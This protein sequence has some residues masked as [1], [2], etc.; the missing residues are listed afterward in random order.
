M[1]TP[2]RRRRRRRRSGLHKTVRLLR[3][4]PYETFAGI[5]GIA[6]GVGAQEWLHVAFNA[7]AIIAGVVAVLLIATKYL[8]GIG[9]GAIYVFD[10][11]HPTT[12]KPVCGYVGKTRQDPRERYRQH[13]GT[14]TR[15][16]GPPQPWSDTVIPGRWRLAHESRW[17]TNI[18]LHVREKANILLRWPLYNY[19][20]N[21][22]NPRRIAPDRA[23][24]LRAERDADLYTRAYA[25]RVLG[26]AT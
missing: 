24:E 12:G 9:Y 21:L 2:A 18:G 23:V 14:S 1:A 4:H 15:Y 7:E 8:L 3:K 20:M 5:A 25:A 16:P 26:V 17:M 19:M 11:Y 6:S 10:V 22:A 13:M